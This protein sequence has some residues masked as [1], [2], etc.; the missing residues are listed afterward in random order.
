MTHHI[1]SLSTVNF[2]IKFL[3]FM[4]Q[5]EDDIEAHGYAEWE[6][7]QHGEV[8]EDTDIDEFKETLFEALLEIEESY[9]HVTSEIQVRHGR[10]VSM[11]SEIRKKNNVEIALYELDLIIK[12]V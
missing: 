3:N 1:L 8:Y 4:D 5:V 10:V 6:I 9:K 12:S 7:A 11:P 2:K